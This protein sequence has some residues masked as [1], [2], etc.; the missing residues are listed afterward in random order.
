MARMI[1]RSGLAVF[2]DGSSD[3]VLNVIDLKIVRIQALGTIQPDDLSRG[4]RPKLSRA[5]REEITRP[6]RVF[7]HLQNVCS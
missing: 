4:V 5:R 1:G 6:R 2:D 3:R 7:F